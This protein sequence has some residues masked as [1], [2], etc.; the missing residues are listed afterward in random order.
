M[1]NPASPDGPSRAALRAALLDYCHSPGK[2]QVGLRQPKLLF[3]EL[4]EIL[5]VAVGREEHASANGKAESASLR[6]AARFFVRTAL[7]YPGADHYA[8]LGLDRKAEGADLKDRYRLM[9]RL[10]HPDFAGP[11]AGAWPM[12]AA[13]RVNRAYDILSSAVQRREYDGRLGQMR[14]AASVPGSD[15]RRPRLEPQPVGADT[16]QSRFKT[17]AAVCALAAA[18]LVVVSLFGTGSSDT[19]HLVQ[20]ATVQPPAVRVAMEDPAPLAQAVAANLREVKAEELSR[21]AVSPAKSP[22]PQIVLAAPLAAPLAAAQK[23]VDLP[24]PAPTQVAARPAPSPPPPAA[25]QPILE[26]VMQFTRSTQVVVAPAPAP[27]PSEP[28]VEVAV[29]VTPLVVAP[30]PQPALIAPAPTVQPAPAPRAAPKPGPSLMEAQPLLSQL[31]QVMESGRGERILNLLEPDARTK[32]SAL[33]LSRQ[34][35]S[36]VEGARPVR[37]SHVEFKAEPG[38]GRLLVIGYFR[39]MAGE[40]TIGTIG[41]KMMVRAE[42]ISR[43]GNV[44]ITGLSGGAVN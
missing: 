9:M 39:V 11:G 21:P 29:V 10:L 28:K 32:P 24:R 41:K 18:A 30:A 13:V 36:L 42:F 33:A 6:D 22:G 38:D 16:R 31:L 23:H 25:S 40:Q 15:A 3:A 44:V 12:D 4:R 7:L 19:V 20:R 35:D 1:H 43:D 26:R 8:L 27:P 14:S 37:V 5:Q 17:L 2:Y 34:Y